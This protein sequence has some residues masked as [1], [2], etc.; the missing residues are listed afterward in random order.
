MFKQACGDFCIT[1]PLLHAKFQKNP[2]SGFRDLAFRTH[3][4][5]HPRTHKSDSISPF[6]LQ[7]GTNY[8]FHLKSLLANQ[9]L[10]IYC[11]TYE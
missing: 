11:N 8:R 5:T 10:Q 3:A 9:M 7:P 6:G 4:R 2:W 1:N